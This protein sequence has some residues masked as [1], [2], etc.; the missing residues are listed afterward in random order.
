MAFDPTTKHPLY[1]EFLPSWKLMRDAVEGEDKIKK[2]GERYLPMKSGTAQIEDPRIKTLS[3]E[4]YKLR[5]EFPE[6]VA[7]T[8]R[9]SVGVI[10][11]QQ[12]AIALSPKLEGL[13]ERAT[14]DGLTLQSL[15]S[16]ICIEVMT[17]GRFGLL[18][19]LTQDSTPYIATYSAENVTNWDVN[20]EQ[21]ND[22]V[23]LDETRQKFD[24]LE[25]KW[26]LD[27]QYRELR[28]NEAGVYEAVVWTSTD[29]KSW[30][31]AAPEVAQR[32]PARGVREGVNEL[33]FV[34][35]NTNDLTPSPDDVPLYG[36]AKLSVRIY[37]LD[38][39]YTFALHM[40]SEPT[41]WVN[42]YETPGDAVKNGDAPN[43]IG[44]AKLWVLPPNATAGFL[45]FTG[46]GLAAQDTAIQNSLKRAVLFGANLLADGQK[47]AE[48]GEALATRLGSQTATLR[49]IAETAASG[50]QKALRNLAVWLG[51]NPEAVTVKPNTDFFDQTLSAQDIMALV[52]GWQADAYS[53]KTLF[54]KLQKGGIISSD[55]DYETEESEIE[56]TRYVPPT[57]PGGGNTNDDPTVTE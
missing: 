57:P 52:A 48:S 28:L 42:G 5:A 11:D 46:P 29:G 39:D 35:V 40:T 1:E 8:I 51:D 14:R 37:R 20:D 30:D 27:Y 6:L 17:T 9:G 49:T 18:P 55:I 13:M 54:N 23:M 33:P 44:A 25:G 31:A 4:A 15:F 36:L 19:G 56:L 26:A 43:S 22:F 45:E 38:A 41:P 21:I 10:V 34:F 50:L 3:Y 16:R 32:A 2:E 7:P 24:R 12:P 47:S 53:K